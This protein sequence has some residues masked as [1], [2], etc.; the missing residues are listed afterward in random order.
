VIVA[1]C[2]IESSGVKANGYMG[3]LI[4]LDEDVGTLESLD[5]AFVLDVIYRCYLQNR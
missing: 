2:R 5:T 4:A 1:D 3:D